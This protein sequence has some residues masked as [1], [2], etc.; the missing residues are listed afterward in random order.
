MT[1]E[2]TLLQDR[3]ANLEERVA[4]LE[5]ELGMARNADQLHILR[6]E[7]RITP[8]AARMLSI[9]YIA[10]GRVVRRL[11]LEDEVC[12]T[13][14]VTNVV[15]LYALYIRKALGPDALETARGEG[16]RLTSSGLQRVKSILENSDAMAA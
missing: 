9:L 13:D 11:F 7:L 8:C 14:T 12:T 3:I 1:N 15:K 4:W 2:L 5:S 6:R 16:Y 10:K